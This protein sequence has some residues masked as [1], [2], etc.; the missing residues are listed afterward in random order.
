MEPTPPGSSRYHMRFEKG[1]ALELTHSRHPT[2]T[3]TEYARPEAGAG[4][5]RGSIVVRAKSPLTHG[6]VCLP[7]QPPLAAEFLVADP[8]FMSCPTTASIT[9]D[10]TKIDFVTGCS[11]IAFLPAGVTG[12]QQRSRAISDTATGRNESI[13][14]THATSSVT[15]C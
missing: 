6:T 2:S 1:T 14:A 9:A 10:H 13:W 15:D 11:M 7:I 8:M 5:D 4:N 12:T 3:F